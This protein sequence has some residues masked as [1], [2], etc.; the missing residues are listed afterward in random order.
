MSNKRVK[1]Q[2]MD[3]AA[4]LV[5][6]QMQ[7]AQDGVWPQVG[8]YGEPLEASSIRAQRA[9]SEIAGSFRAAFAGFKSDGKARVEA[10]GFCRWWQCRQICDSC[11]AERETNS[12]NQALLYKDFRECAGW[13]Q[14]VLSHT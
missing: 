13:R 5:G 7:V 11:L 6:W 9:G 3:L 12:C 1:R 4:R 10:N 2:V 14:T 8:F